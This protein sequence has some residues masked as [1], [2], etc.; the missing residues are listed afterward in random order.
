MSGPPSCAKLDSVLFPHNLSNQFTQPGEPCFHISSDVHPQCSTI[1]FRQHREVSARL[2]GLH[3]A[4]RI[5]LPRNLKVLCVVARY[6]QKHTAI[7]AAFVCLS[8]RVEK[9]RTKSQARRDALPISH[10][11]PQVLQQTFILRVHL[12]IGEHG[13]IVSGLKSRQMRT[14]IILQ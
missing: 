13:K 14:Q 7:R 1:S 12:H 11:S 2:R 8:R 4:E 6:L 3:Y 9:A 10:H 5:L